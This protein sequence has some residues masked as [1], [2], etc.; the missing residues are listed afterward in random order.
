MARSTGSN[1]ENLRTWFGT[2]VYTGLSSKS[3][4]N[5]VTYISGRDEFSDTQTYAYEIITENRGGYS[6]RAV[7]PD[8]FTVTGI[9]SENGTRRTDFSSPVYQCLKNS[10]TGE[11]YLAENPALYLFSDQDGRFILSGAESW[12]YFFDYQFGNDWYAVA[13][14]VGDE[15]DEEKRV[16]QFMDFDASSLIPFEKTEDGEI[17][18]GFEYVP[19][20]ELLSDY[21][22]FG[23]L[24]GGM[25]VDTSAFWSSL[26]P[27]FDETEDWSSDETIPEETVVFSAE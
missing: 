13:F 19:A 9:I 6:I 18:A 12:L 26:F 7:I 4:N 10:E 21:Y 8:V 20:V 2:G 27:E 1:A 14:E 15:E 24:E 5:L 23:I 3:R 17:A 16:W 11:L 22:G 25:A